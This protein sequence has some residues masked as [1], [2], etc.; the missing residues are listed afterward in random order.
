MEFVIKKYVSSKNLKNIKPDWPGTPVDEK[1]RFVNHE[2][3]FK[4]DFFKLLKWQLGRNP[5]ATEKRSD[6]V[7]L[8][9]LDPTEFLQSETEGILW[10]GHASFF[11]SF[12]RQS[13]FAGSGFWSSTVFEAAG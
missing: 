8:E 11:Y 2:F 9:V 13:D 5:Q 6:T 1:G 7:R 10:L 4:H 3:P 12:G